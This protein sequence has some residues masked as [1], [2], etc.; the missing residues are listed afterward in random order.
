MQL[1]KIQAASEPLR[2]GRLAGNHF[3]LIIR[4][5]KPHKCSSGDLKSLVNEAVENV[6]VNQM[7]F[8]PLLYLLML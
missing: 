3:A 7:Y 5:L 6:K 1:S 2:L 4:D 8:N